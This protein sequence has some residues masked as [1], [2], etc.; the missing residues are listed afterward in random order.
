[1]EILHNGFTLKLCDGAFPLSTDSVALSGFVKLPKNARVLDLCSGCGTLGLLLCARDTGC[2]VTGVE[3]DEAAHETALINARENHI[4]GRLTSICADLG[5]AALPAGQFQICV[6]NP[7]YFTAGPASRHCPGGRMEHSLS[8]KALF[9]QAARAL[10]YGGD[11]Y[12]VHRPERLGEICAL[13]S[14]CQLEPKRLLLLRHRTDAPISLIL[15]QCRKGGKPG[16]AIEEASLY[17]PDGTYTDYY[18]SLYHLQEV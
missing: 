11:F 1:M 9:L 8:L 12:L 6:S 5:T 7:P 16:L 15:V 10:R 3:I 17:H 4:E 14:S 13:G 18:K 2:C